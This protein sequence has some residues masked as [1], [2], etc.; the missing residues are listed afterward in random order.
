[1]VQWLRL[2]TSTARGAGLILGQET[3]IPHATQC[4]QKTKIKYA[5]ERIKVLRRAR[6]QGVGEVS[7]RQKGRLEDKALLR[8]HRMIQLDKGFNLKNKM[9]PNVRLMKTSKT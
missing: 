8:I 3:K 5:A 1:M 9:T 4:S 7:F 6:I 2:C